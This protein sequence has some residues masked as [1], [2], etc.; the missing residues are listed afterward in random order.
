MLEASET[1][2]RFVVENGKMKCNLAGRTRGKRCGS[3][4]MI[5][6]SV[7]CSAGH[8][9]SVDELVVGMLHDNPR[10]LI[11]RSFLATAG[12][13]NELAGKLAEVA[14]KEKFS[15]PYSMPRSEKDRYGNDHIY[16]WMDHDPWE[17]TMLLQLAD[18]YHPD[19]AEAMRKMW[20]ERSGQK[21]E[22]L[23]KALRKLEQQA[24]RGDFRS[25]LHRDHLIWSIEKIL[26]HECQ[27]QGDPILPH[28]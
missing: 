8:K 11:A 10:S 15:P 2:K 13:N 6:G 26:R 25:E 4:L 3:T 27:E 5:D 14:L 1:R 24:E 20:I 16:R 9:F 12:M 18:W 17:F 23:N 7:V 19:Y 28:G 21:N 22:V